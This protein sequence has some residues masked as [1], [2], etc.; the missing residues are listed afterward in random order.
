MSMSYCLFENT[1]KDLYQIKNRL[2]AAGSWEELLEEASEYEAEAM[3]DMPKVLAEIL[4][5]YDNL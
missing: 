5:H 1:L 4:N 2:R 3:R